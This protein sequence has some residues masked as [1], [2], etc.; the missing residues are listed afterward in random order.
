[1]LVS[2]P[3][4]LTPPSGVEHVAVR[5]AE[6]M[7]DAVG[8]RAEAATVVLMAAAVS[9][10]RPAEKA[11]RKVKKGAGGATL[12][13]VRTPD[14]LRGLGGKKGARV[15]VGFAAET[16]HLREN[17]RKKLAEKNLDLIVAN[18]V[19]REGAGFESETNAAVLIDRD[20]GETETALQS[21]RELADRI[22]DHVLALRAARRE[23]VTQD[24]S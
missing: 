10:Y 24:R 15:L 18:D 3:T 2:G 19:T 11:P 4:S 16:D 1:M 9:D 14:I 12:E 17:A 21:K 20:G 6:E 7:A 8:A 22:L 23:H 13:L 5:S